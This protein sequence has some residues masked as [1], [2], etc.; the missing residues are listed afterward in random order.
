V[1]IPP[2]IVAGLDQHE[3]VAPLRHLIDRVSSVRSITADPPT[4]AYVAVR[5]A[6]WGNVSAYIHRD[7][8]DVA[9]TP[10]RARCVAQSQVW[11]LVRI[12]SETGFIR[13]QADALADVDA[14]DLATTLMLQAVDKSESGTAYEGG[15]S[16]RSPAKEPAICPTFSMTLP[17]SGVCD[18]CG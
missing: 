15:G 12:N 11:P 14:A 9:L 1:A 2:E 7:Y 10:E 8:A 13:I 17:S 5:P 4:A 3:V 18:T 6:A 16:T